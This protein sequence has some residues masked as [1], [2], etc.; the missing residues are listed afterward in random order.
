MERPGFASHFSTSLLKTKTS[1][2]R[3]ECSQRYLAAAFNR[4]AFHD[5]GRGCPCMLICTREL[6]HAG[7]HRYLRRH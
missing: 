2:G 4:A 7:P 5:S 3:R 1:P 6:G